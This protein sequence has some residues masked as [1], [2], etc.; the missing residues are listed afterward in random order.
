RIRSE[1]LSPAVGQAT[2]W[3]VFRAGENLTSLQ[4][5][6]VGCNRLVRAEPFKIGSDEYNNLEY[7]HSYISNGLPM[8][9]SVF[10]K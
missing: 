6:Y 2:H 1:V 7:F 4:T 3:P 8:Q 5:R 10:R 9:A